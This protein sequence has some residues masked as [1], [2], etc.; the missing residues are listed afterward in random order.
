MALLNC[1]FPEPEQM[2]FALQM[3]REFAREAG[4]CYAGGLTVGGGEAIHGRPLASTGGMTHRLDVVA[5][6]VEHEGAEVVRVVR[7]ARAGATV[8]L[9]AGRHREGVTGHGLARPRDAAH[10]ADEVKIG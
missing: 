6:G 8:V 9:A 3:L 1:G 4:Y 5:I 2:R 7:G 10:G